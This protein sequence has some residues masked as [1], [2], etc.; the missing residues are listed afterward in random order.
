M[1][2]NETKLLILTPDFP[3][4]DGGVAVWAEKIAKF[5]TL[6]GCQVVVAAPQQLAEDAEFDR[7]Q[8]Y[9][10][11]R[12]KNLKARY[13]K[14]FWAKFAVKLLLRAHKPSH[15]LILTWYPYANAVLD[16]AQGVPIT[17]MAH[18]NDFMESR[19]QQDGWRDRMKRAFTGARHIIAVSQETQRM[20]AHYSLGNQLKNKVLFPAV[21][22][23]EFQYAEAFQGPPVL[24]TLGRVVQRKGQD[25]VI[26][27]LP[28]ILQKFPDV[29]YW[30]AGKGA[31]I[32][33]LK[34][35]VN[36][37]G[38]IK[39]V[40]FLGFVSTAERIKL[41]HRCSIYLMPSRAIG[42]RG[43][44]EGFGITYLEA[45]ACGRPV[46]GGKSG[47]VSDAVW[48]GIN[49]FL[50]DPNSPEEIADR[51]IQLLE[52][53]KMAEQFALNGRAR[54]ENELNWESTAKRLWHIM[55]M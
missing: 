25:M 53:P 47:G 35:L 37:T 22:P 3:P 29:E 50:V 12:L 43:D 31:D 4:W 17:L 24:L 2:F 20:L 55:K 16:S 11:V 28:A 46:I 49:G 38:V 26:R 9:K 10:V 23:A 8:S 27:A 51:V 18:G 21:D 14:Y 52:S 34:E 5:L 19:W 44:F 32:P 6:H 41:Y 39:N 54:I 33:R 30:I 42:D 45:N 7:S 36:N 13:L 40:R 15:I 1:S 48:D